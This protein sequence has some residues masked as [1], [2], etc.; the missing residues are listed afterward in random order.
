MDVWKMNFL[1]HFAQTDKDNTKRTV[2]FWIISS[3]ILTLLVTV[4]AVVSLHSSKATVVEYI[5]NFFPHEDARIILSDHRLQVENIPQPF[6][7]EFH[8]DE[9]GTAGDAV[10]IIDTTQ[11]STYGEKTLLEYDAGIVILRDRMYSKDRNQALQLLLFEQEDF[12]NFSL[13]RG[14]VLQFIEDKYPLFEVGAGVVVFL[15]FLFIFGVLR[16]L[17]ALWWAFVLWV[18]AKIANVSLTYGIAYKAV[19][20]F[21]FIVTMV[22]YTVNF[23]R[24]HVPFLATMIFL[25]IFVLNLRWM[26]KHQENPAQEKA[27]KSN[28]TEKEEKDTEESTKEKDDNNNA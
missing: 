3:T 22:T 14:E 26:K 4:Y 15:L 17:G 13:S 23:G 11:D 25:L 9:D 7:R 18:C 24:L 1:A 5:Q 21:S 27:E 6:L 8:A 2:A 20:H 28:D 19:M 10:L 16:L 12:P